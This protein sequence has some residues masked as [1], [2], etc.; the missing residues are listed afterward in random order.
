MSANKYIKPTKRLRSPNDLNKF[1]E[2]N[3]YSELVNFITMLASSVHGLELTDTS[4]PIDEAI[5]SVMDLLTDVNDL[6]DK[7]AV[8][9]DTSSRFGKIEFKDFYDDLSEN[10]SKLMHKRLKFQSEGEVDDP[11]VELSEY[12]LNSFGDRTRIDYGSGHELNFT[13]FLLCLYKLN[14]FTNT[15]VH[16]SIV[17]KIFNSYLNTMRKLQLKYW[18]EPAGSHGVWG[19]DDYHFLPFLFGAAQLSPFNRPRPLSV[20]NRDYVDEYKDKYLYFGCIAFINDVKT[21]ADSLRWHSPMLDDISGVKTW[22]KIEEGMIKMYKAEVLGKLPVV[23]HFMFG[24]ILVCPE[25][26]GA[27]EEEEESGHEHHHHH[28]ENEGENVHSTWGDCCGIKVPS[29]VAARAMEKNKHHI[30]FD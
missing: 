1:I 11:T 2:S 17:L 23:Q 5:Q 16:K 30:P 13:C 6:I 10:I 26:I 9:N 21:G 4:L 3:T 24:S 22:K 12:L 8:V 28:S 18:L 15:D 25:D 20:H 29:A 19:L 27:E 14:Y 7:H